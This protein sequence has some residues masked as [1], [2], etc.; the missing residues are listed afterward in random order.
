MPKQAH[1]VSSG[2]ELEYGLLQSTKSKPHYFWNPKGLKVW[3]WTDMYVTL[4]IS[5][6]H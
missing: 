2:E 6:E 4:L 3:I 1:P 5:M